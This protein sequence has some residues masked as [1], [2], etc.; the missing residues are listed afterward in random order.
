MAHAGDG[1]SVYRSAALQQAGPGVTAEGSLTFGHPMMQ[2]CMPP[3]ASAPAHVTQGQQRRRQQQHEQALE[4]LEHTGQ[5]DEEEQEGLG[6]AAGAGAG[7]RATAAA[8]AAAAEQQRQGHG[9][10]PAVLQL[11]LI[12]ID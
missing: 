1:A 5:Q 11:V 4:G 7:A 9:R 3:R 2:M 12:T 10:L 8:A 6:A